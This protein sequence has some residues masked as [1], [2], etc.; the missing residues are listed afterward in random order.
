MFKYYIHSFKKVADQYP[1]GNKASN[2]LLKAVYSYLKLNNPEKAGDSFKQLIR[3][4]PFSDAAQSAED[5][6]KTIQEDDGATKR[7]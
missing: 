3:N 4:Y 6:L 2:A 7:P 5:K 1:N